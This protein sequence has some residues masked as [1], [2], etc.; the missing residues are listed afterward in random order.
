MPIRFSRGARAIQSS[1]EA[2]ASVSLTGGRSGSGATTASVKQAKIDASR[3]VRAFMGA[4]S[5]ERAGA[6]SQQRPHQRPLLRGGE[7]GNGAG[8]RG[9]LAALDGTGRAGVGVARR[10]HQ[11]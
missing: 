11:R 3:G 4:G 1:K 7:L 5:L 8:G 9:R 6:A 2:T 10:L